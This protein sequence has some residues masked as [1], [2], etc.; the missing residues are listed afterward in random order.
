MLQKPPLYPYRPEWYLAQSNGQET[1]LKQYLTSPENES[2]NLISKL[3]GLQ[4]E[5]KWNII[6]KVE[7]TTNN[8]FL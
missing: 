1:F 3:S 2:K 5:A 7:M 8:V 4:P 6:I